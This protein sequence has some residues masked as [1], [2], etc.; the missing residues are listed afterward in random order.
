MDITWVLGALVGL[1]L[2]TTAYFARA[3]LQVR[4]ENVTLQAALASEAERDRERELMKAEFEALSQKLLS[5]RSKELSSQHSETLSQVL[6]PLTTELDAFKKRVNEVYERETRD[7]VSLRQEIVSLKAL[8]EKMST[9]AL[10][11]TRALKGENKTAGNWGELVLDQVLTASGLREGYEYTRQQSLTDE[12]GARLQPDVIVSLPDD[13]CLI[14]DAKLSLKEYERA[15]SA[16]DD[17]TRPAALKAHA[18]SLKAHVRGLSG[19]NYAG[20][21]GITTVDF[22]I[23]F[24]PVEP[25]F[26]AAFETAPQLFTDA[27]SQGV[28]IAS[29]STLLALLRTVDHVWR[30]ENQ[31]KNTRQIA[32]L[33]GKLYDQ[34]ALFAESFED[35]GERIKKSQ[36][37]FEKA[38]NRL[39][40]G[41]GNVLRRAEQ[42]KTLGVASTRQLPESLQD[43]DD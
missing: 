36:E 21:P 43:L 20:L 29:P 33:G 5:E 38:T 34:F 10:N 28:V 42:L 2:A 16:V 30:I 40:T 19:K 9:D 6:K 15:V 14:I 27:L 1:G 37:A 17:S 11:L 39:S 22:V 41:R 31:N 13:K 7:R 23:M 24:V 8:N 26:S 4:D 18:N 25:A 32:E 35:V 12:D 3:W